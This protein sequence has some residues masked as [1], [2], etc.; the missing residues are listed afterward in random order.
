[1]W[2]ISLVTNEVALIEV[3][4]LERTKRGLVFESG[5]VILIERLFQ[6]THSIHVRIGLCIEV[7]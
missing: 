1:M 2:F 6:R 3:G 5:F 7:Y 4:V